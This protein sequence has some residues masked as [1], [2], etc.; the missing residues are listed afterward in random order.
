MIDMMDSFMGIFGYKRPEVWEAERNEHDQRVQRESADSHTPSF[1]DMSNAIRA[2]HDI[3]NMLEDIHRKEAMLNDKRTHEKYDLPL[4]WI[5]IETPPY[6]TAFVNVLNRDGS[7]SCVY[8]QS[9]RDPK[10]CFDPSAVAWQHLKPPERIDAWVYSDGIDLFKIYKKYRDSCEDSAIEIRV[11]N[12]PREISPE[13]LAENIIDILN[14]MQDSNHGN[15]D[16]GKAKMP[17]P[18][19]HQHNP[20]DRFHL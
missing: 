14:E 8:F 3:R 9:E 10:E 19:T 12:L 4:G 7:I 20:G 6:S 5:S 16:R 13:V 11:C 2:K 18:R 17:P 15:P 1:W